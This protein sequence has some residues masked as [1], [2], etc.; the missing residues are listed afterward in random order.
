MDE[1]I[2]AV[3]FCLTTGTEFSPLK[4]ILFVCVMPVYFSFVGEDIINFQRASSG[5]SLPKV[6]LNLRCFGVLRVGL[7]T[8]WTAG[9]NTLAGTEAAP[10]G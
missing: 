7:Q 3:D 5:V 8:P 1:P 6:S 4:T 10:L 2:T 9:L